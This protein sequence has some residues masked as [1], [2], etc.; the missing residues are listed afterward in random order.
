MKC[1]YCSQ[2]IAE[3]EFNTIVYSLDETFCLHRPKGEEA[4]IVKKYDQ[5]GYKVADVPSILKEFT[6]WR[7]K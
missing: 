4:S 3:N 6:D 5:G 7:K 1:D 2:D